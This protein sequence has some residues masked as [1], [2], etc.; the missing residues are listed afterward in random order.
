MKKVFIILYIILIST[1]IFAQK[2]IEPEEIS[3]R[4]YKERFPEYNQSFETGKTDNSYIIWNL[5]HG[6]KI[7]EKTIFIDDDGYS[8]FYYKNEKYT[9][10]SGSNF[11][12]S[13]GS[14]FWSTIECYKPDDIEKYYNENCFQSDIFSDGNYLPKFGI[15]NIN[16]SSFYSEKTKSNIINYV[17]TYLNVL[18]NMYID[19][20]DYII[21]NPW[22]PGKEKNKSGIEE[23][24][25][26]EFEDLKD[27]LVILNGYVDLEKRY[28]YKANN[29]V[30]VAVITSLD[31]DNPF[32]IEYVFEDYVH[33]SE[34]KFPKSVHKIRFTIR[35][36]YKGEKWDDT[37]ITSVITRWEE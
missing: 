36:I 4:Q 20:S 29:R 34:I 19:K 5:N 27:N 13:F 24:L 22:V 8:N 26:I 6:I 3:K 37:C 11:F 12:F 7:D 31:K 14:P 25:D 35:E 2:Y 33:F 32:E 10:L 30:K 28:L 15:S 9:V 21:K 18:I 23:Y 16:S 1:N 17:P